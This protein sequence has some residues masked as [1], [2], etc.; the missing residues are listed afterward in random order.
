MLAQKPPFILRPQI[1]VRIDRINR[2]ET[3][4]FT[5]VKEIGSAR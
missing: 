3:I 2:E 1:S 5:G 4:I